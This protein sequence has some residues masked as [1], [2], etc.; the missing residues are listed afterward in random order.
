MKTKIYR[1]IKFIKRD[2]L[3]KININWLD[4]TICVCLQKEE[5]RTQNFPLN[6]SNGDQMQTLLPGNWFDSAI[7]EAIWTVAILGIVKEILIFAYHHLHR[8]F[9]PFHTYQ[10]QQHASTVSVTTSSREIMQRLCTPSNKFNSRFSVEQVLCCVQPSMK[11]EEAPHNEIAD[12]VGKRVNNG[13][14][15]AKQMLTSLWYSFSIQFPIIW[16]LRLARAL[17][18]F[19]QNQAF[20]LKWLVLNAKLLCFQHYLCQQTA[21]FLGKNE[22]FDRQY[23]FGIETF[24]DWNI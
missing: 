8:Q 11:M 6:K 1:T 22:R 16:K 23:Q 14:C 4:C 18:F 17:A 3:Y 13:I 7:K 21:H 2:S 19:S 24:D 10:S 20:N 12:E 9:E 15:Y 5:K